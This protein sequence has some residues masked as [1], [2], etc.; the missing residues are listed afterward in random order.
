M[1]DMLLLYATV[2]CVLFGGEYYFKKT[3][4]DTGLIFLACISWYALFY[5]SIS[6]FYMR[7]V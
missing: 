4:C 5:F 7:A 2:A 1:Q 6:E 3:C